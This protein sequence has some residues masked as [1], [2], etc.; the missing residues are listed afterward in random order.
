MRI[1]SSRPTSHREHRRATQRQPSPRPFALSAWA[2]SGR[3]QSRSQSAAKRCC[4]LLIAALICLCLLPVMA[5][6][7]L[8]VRFSSPGPILYRQRRVGK[9]GQPFTIYKFR[10]M[11]A[12]NDSSAHQTYYAAL[13]ANTAAPSAGTFKLV[14]DPRITSAG[15][16]LRKLSIDELPQIFNILRGEMSLV[17]PRPPLPYEVMLYD[18]QAQRRLCVQPGLTGLWQVSGRNALNF[19]QMIELDLEYIRC[20]SLLLDLQIL[21]LT[22]WAVIKA[23]GAA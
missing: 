22:P 18:E 3:W 20:W 5:V 15:R 21:C 11:H 10:T 14:N 9:N 23:A 8:L 16:V 17:G 2:P 1:S 13:I 12:N 4:D 19:R 6:A 7:A